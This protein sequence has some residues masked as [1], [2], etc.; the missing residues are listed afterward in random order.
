MAAVF[1][2][3]EVYANMDSMEGKNRQWCYSNAELLYQGSGETFSD[4]E[5]N[6]DTTIYYKIF[7][8]YD[9]N[10]D[11][12]Y[13]SGVETNSKTDAQA[14][15]FLRISSG[16]VDATLFPNGRHIVT[17]QNQ[18][19]S[20]F[21]FLG[22]VSGHT[23]VFC[24]K[25]KDGV[26]TNMNFPLIEGYRQIQPT[27]VIDTNNRI[28]VVFAGRDSDHPMV[29]Q[30]KYTTFLDTDFFGD[31]IWST[32][33]NLDPHNT[34]WRAQP[35]L[36][37]DSSNNLHLTYGCMLGNYVNISYIKKTGTTWESIYQFNPNGY[38]NMILPSI[39]IDSSNNPHIVCY[40]G[41]NLS[42]DGDRIVYNYFNGTSWVSFIENTP[43]F[44]NNSTSDAGNNKTSALY[45]NGNIGINQSNPRFGIDVND[46]EEMVKEKELQLEEVD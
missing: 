11:I 29:E 13:S 17:D 46:L 35:S 45:R 15:A 44:I 14:Q 42:N 8:V 26:L 21:V 5:R 4:T 12:T 40:A 37:V 25:Y 16:T 7:A 22:V 39:D 36:V 24:Y 2:G 38:L 41:T 27:I 19:V 10:G 6:P 23:Q 1:Q 30:I 34:Y 43:F 32:L 20:Y 33:L 31:G 9:D 28:H 3:V 18:T